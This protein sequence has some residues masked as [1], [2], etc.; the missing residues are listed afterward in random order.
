MDNDG[1]SPSVADDTQ[2]IEHDGDP[3]HAD[4]LQGLEYI[5]DATK[6]ETMKE[7][8]TAPC[9]IVPYAAPHTV[10]NWRIAFCFC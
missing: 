10:H 7:V 2:S 3:G 4:Y 9:L 1:E 8:L 6:H 5:A